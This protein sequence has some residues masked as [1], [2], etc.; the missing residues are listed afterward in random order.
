MGL[1]PVFDGHSDIPFRV[2]REEGGDGNVLEED[3]LPA[4]RSS[5]L[6]GRVAAVYVHDDFVPEMSLHRALSMIRAMRSEAADAEGAEVVTTVSELREN[7]AEGTVSFVLGMEGAEPLVGDVDLLDVYYRLGV[8]VLG[9]THSRRNHAGDGATL[10][11]SGDGRAVTEGGISRFGF[12]VVD[13]M[14]ELGMVVDTVHLNETGFWDVVAASSDPVLNTHSNC[15]SLCDHPRN[16]TDE[17]IRAVADTGGVVGA[18][19]LGLTFEAEEPSLDD[20]I[21]HVDHMVE[22]VGVDHV[23]V[24]FDYY[25]Y[26]IE[27]FDG[28]I[29]DEHMSVDGLWDDSEVGG[30]P[31]ALREAGYA[32]EEVR[33]MLWEN[34]LRVLEEVID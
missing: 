19:A 32:D 5:G 10:D 23:G 12:E 27:Y 18:T 22:L 1:T 7:A 13:R 25:E 9:L 34:Q 24:G 2:V 20:F 21:A 31:S 14:N 28:F 8:R 33:K 11:V 29:G 4:M 30:L 6:M 17:Q 26:L 16:L 15:R 3:F